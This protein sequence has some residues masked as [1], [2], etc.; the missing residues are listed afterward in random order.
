MGRARPAF[1]YHGGKWK[2]APWIISHFPPH[3]VYVECY[4]GS[5]AVLLRK[6][7][8]YAEVYNDLSDDLV[9]FFEVLRDPVEAA[10]LV[11]LV[12]LTPFSRVE[13]KRAYKKEQDP[14][15]RACALLVRAY[16]GFGSAS[17]I[18]DHSTGFRANSHRSGTTPAHDWMNYPAS[19]VKTIERM[20][21]VVIENRKAIDCMRQHDSPDTL[22]YVDPPYV[23][24]TRAFKRRKAGQVYSHEMDDKDHEQL[25]EYL[26]G[27][28]GMVALSGYAS[29]MYDTLYARG[30]GW[31][32]R[33]IAAHADGARRRKEV[34]WLNQAC[35]DRMD[36]T[37]KDLFE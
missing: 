28:E 31:H 23:Q 13:F 12:S 30:G 11:E 36:K 8:A 22:F 7:R 33:E 17:V 20:R 6:E 4:G 32:S 2:L 14:G 5:A 18:S 15:R 3:R 35:F 24:S 1:R 29:P 25:A 16:M 27:V 37:T 34:L 10:R 19:L 9:N 26:N 21:G